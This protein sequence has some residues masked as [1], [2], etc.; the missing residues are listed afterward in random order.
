MPRDP[1]GVAAVPGLFGGG[2]DALELIDHQTGADAGVGHG[3]CT[4]RGPSD[5][6]PD[7]VAELDE[8]ALGVPERSE[9]D[10]GRLHGRLVVRVGAE[11]QPVPGKDETAAHV[12]DAARDAIRERRVVIHMPTS[13]IVG[14]WRTLE[15]PARMKL[16][17]GRS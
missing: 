10:P 5:V 17:N 12:G 11:D 13:H 15:H 7:L 8:A 3:E 6:D 1:E 16:V 9:P 2:Q 14:P 4:V